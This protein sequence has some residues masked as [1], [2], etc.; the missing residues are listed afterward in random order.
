MR[1]E[2]EV[3]P[4]DVLFSRPLAAAD[5]P[6]EGLDV[7]IS[8]TQAEL[9]ALAEAN[10]LPAVMRLDARL[11]VTRAGRDGLDVRGELTADA[12]QTC[13]VTLDDF[14]IHLAEPIHLR[15][16]P[17]RDA[18]GARAAGAGRGQAVRPD[19]ACGHH[20]GGED[21]DPPDPLVGGA[22]DLGAI[23]S[24]FFTL[25]LDPYPRKPGARFD[26]PARAGPG[27]ETSPFAR[28]RAALKT[29]SANDGG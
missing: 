21:D 24:E 9:A 5:V 8:A 23:A 27:R 13:V 19:A 25:G 20:V 15:F 10:G 3:E 12:R 6:P 18:A 17:G 28:L 29:P 4:E 11:L 26:E 22:I 14:D 1:R 16:A 2:H 7:E